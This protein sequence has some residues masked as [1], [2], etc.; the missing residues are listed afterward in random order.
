MGQY[1]RPIIITPDG[2]RQMLISH[3][4]GRSGSKLTEHSW[5][6]NEFVN[7]VISLI[8]NTPQKVA[9][10]GDYA[11]QQYGED[12]NEAYAKIMPLNEFQKYYDSVWGEDREDQDGLAP[13]LFSS[14]D[15]EILG[16]GTKGMFIVNHDKQEYIN[17]TVYIRDN[18]SKGG[19][20][21][22]WCMNPLPLLTAC[23]NGRGGGD[24]REN[25]VGFEDIGIWAFDTLEYTAK[26]PES[27]NEAIF[28]FDEHREVTTV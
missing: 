22:G 17:M 18:T 2:S 21:D 13:N 23:G 26:M 24:F 28:Y 20:W 15:L 19:S 11:Y 25:C 6:S 27:Y 9:W 10:I 12:E 7:A 4:F 14:R 8:H 3:A 16:Y 1:Y 5:I